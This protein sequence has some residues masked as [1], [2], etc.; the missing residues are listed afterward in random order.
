MWPI[1]PA[2]Q[3]VLALPGAKVGRHATVHAHAAS[4]LTSHL[5][6]TTYGDAVPSLEHLHFQA[7]SLANIDFVDPGHA[8]YLHTRDSTTRCITAPDETP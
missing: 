2:P 8:L 1:D 5:L 6:S 4:C 3:T 7:A